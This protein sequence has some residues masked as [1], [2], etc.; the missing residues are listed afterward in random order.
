MKNKMTDYVGSMFNQKH[1]AKKTVISIISVFLM[2]FGIA[3]FSLSKMGVDPYTA[4]NMGISSK[5]GISFGFWLLI[6]NSVIISFVVALAHRGLIGVG[7]VFNMVGVGFV[8][9]YFKTTLSPVLKVDTAIES[10][11]IMSVGLVVLCFAASLFFTTSI[12]VGAYDTISF[13]IGRRTGIPY[14]WCRMISDFFV[15]AFA[16]LISGY[17]NMGFGTVV[18]AFFMG[19]LVSFFNK[20]VSQK[21]LEKN[22]AELSRH[23]LAIY[24]EGLIVTY[25]NPKSVCKIAK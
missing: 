7:T 18:A 13:M 15:I 11:L 10:V 12:G 2:G 22:Y 23:A 16:F 25:A 21:L 14:K 1:M 20:T 9:D 17:E 3:L 4:M 8:C 6:I 24:I 5:I 19:P